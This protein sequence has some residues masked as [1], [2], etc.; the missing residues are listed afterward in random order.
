MKKIA[1]IL[2]FIIEMAGIGFAQAPS[3]IARSS[4][5][6]VKPMWACLKPLPREK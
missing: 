1:V 3:K 4:K 5:T 2:L 6:S